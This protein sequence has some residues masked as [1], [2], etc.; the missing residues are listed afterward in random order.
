LPIRRSEYIIGAGINR[1]EIGSIQDI[2][3]HKMG[4]FYLMLIEDIKTI[5]AAIPAQLKDKNS[6]YSFEFTVAERKAFL[7][8]K[9]LTYRATFRLDEAKKELLFSELLKESSSGLSASSGDISPGFGFKSETY[10]TGT[11][12]REGTIAEQSNLFGK[13]YT[14][15]FDYSKIRKEIEGL[16]EN[17]GYIFKYR[18]TSI[19][20]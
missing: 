6:L 8:T 13:Q 19:G 20:L 9:K 18:L 1:N 17:A 4:R 12:P 11:G 14:Y 16:V 7:S 3:A 5:I 2:V 15:S 10:K